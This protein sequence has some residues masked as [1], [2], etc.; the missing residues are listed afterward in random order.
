MPE[1]L[2]QLAEALDARGW[3]N[4]DGWDCGILYAK[5]HI[6]KSAEAIVRTAEATQELCARYDTEISL[7]DAD[8][9]WDVECSRFVTLYRI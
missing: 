8:T 6:E 1:K 4:T 7:I 3:V 9:S 5:V 2:R